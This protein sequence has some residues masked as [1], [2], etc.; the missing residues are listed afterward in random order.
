MS[1]LD[2]T[3][4]TRHGNRLVLNA[5]SCC[6]ALH[7]VWT[8]F[9]MILGPNGFYYPLSCHATPWCRHSVRQTLKWEVYMWRNCFVYNKLEFRTKQ[10][11][12]VQ[13][14][15]VSQALNPRVLQRDCQCNLFAISHFRKINEVASPC[16]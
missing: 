16:E 8:D 10:M 2:D 9:L 13:A 12:C 15:W 11:C 1:T 5:L 6:V 7:P 4:M 14:Y 3:G